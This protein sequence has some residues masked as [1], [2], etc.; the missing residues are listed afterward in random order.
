MTGGAGGPDLGLWIVLTQILPALGQS[1]GMGED[2][3]DRTLTPAHQAVSDGNVHF[4][5][6]H[7]IQAKE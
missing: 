3:L 4:S 2:D 7:N 1:L 6:N 5:Y